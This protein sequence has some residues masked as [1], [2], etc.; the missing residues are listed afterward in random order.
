MSTIATYI[1]EGWR[2][3]RIVAL[4][5]FAWGLLVATGN[6]AEASPGLKQVFRSSQTMEAGIDRC[7]ATKQGRAFLDCVATELN[8]YSG[9]LATKGAEITA[10]QGAPTASTAAAGVKAA[11]T[12]ATAASVL[13]RTASVMSSLAASS[14]K[15]TRR[16]YTR[17]NQA[18]SKA[19]TTL[20]SKG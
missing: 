18:F 17:I 2:A 11:G 1:T 7:A 12:N 6:G 14:E 19:A 4:L 9:R 3:L 16:A 8:K 20:A 10:P 15:E 5:F 13:E